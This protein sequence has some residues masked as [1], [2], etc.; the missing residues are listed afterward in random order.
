MRNAF[1][2]CIDVPLLCQAAEAILGTVVQ[3]TAILEMR[4]DVP[5]SVQWPSEHVQP[6]Y[7]QLTVDVSR[8]I[9]AGKERQTHYRCPDHF[10][11]HHR[12]SAPLDR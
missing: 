12:L 8:S 11:Y 6:R 7:Q 1:S 10:R 2:T 5:E 9:A 3:R 4:V